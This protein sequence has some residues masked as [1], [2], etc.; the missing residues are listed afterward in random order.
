MPVLLLTFKCLVMSEVTMWHVLIH[1]LSAAQEI[2]KLLRFRKLIKKQSVVLWYTIL[3]T[4][5]NCFFAIKKLTS[6]R[7]DETE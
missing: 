5:K 1:H 6:L 3:F 7:A 2:K 4:Q